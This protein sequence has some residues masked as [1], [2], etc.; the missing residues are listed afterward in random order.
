MSMFPSW[1]VI[2]PQQS[3]GNDTPKRSGLQRAILSA[4]A[5]SAMSGATA[6]EA[7]SDVELCRILEA[8]TLDFNQRAIQ[9]QPPEFQSVTASVDCQ[10]KMYLLDW[11]FRSSFV[12][13]LGPITKRMH[14][15]LLEITCAPDSGWE[16]AFS[17]GWTSKYVFI[18]QKG[19]LI[20][21]IVVNEC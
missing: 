18:D 11:Q 15:Y 9:S 3:L 13:E 6:E 10:E 7:R 4:V 12:D 2:K 14:E 5:L 17:H 16:V 8:R 20:S 19:Q 21:S 1:I